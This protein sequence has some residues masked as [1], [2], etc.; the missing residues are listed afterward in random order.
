MAKH[1]GE[2]GRRLCEALYRPGRKQVFPNSQVKLTMARQGRVIWETALEKTA[3]QF[4]TV[5]KVEICA[6]GD[7][8][9][10]GSWV[11]H[12]RKAGNN[13]AHHLRLNA[14]NS[15][16]ARRNRSLARRLF[17]PLTARQ[18]MMTVLLRKR[19]PG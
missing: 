18:T 2:C 5:K 13:S 9:S 4:P 17:L 11:S 19:F 8:L 15:G 16:V 7:A 12:F 1:S 6:V 14:E 10:I 3:R